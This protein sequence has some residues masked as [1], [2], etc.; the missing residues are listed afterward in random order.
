MQ[1]FKQFYMSH[2][3]TNQWAHIID[4]INMLYHISYHH[5]GGGGGVVL[6]LR[7]NFTGHQ[8]ATL[9]QPLLSPPPP[10]SFCTSKYYTFPDTYQLTCVHPHSENEWQVPL[11]IKTVNQ[12]GVEKN[13]GLIPG[14]SVVILGEIHSRLWIRVYLM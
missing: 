4:I 6:R 1:T 12:I 14:S 7:C 8:L 11:C 3:L 13:T 2:T 5:Y 10:Q 9:T